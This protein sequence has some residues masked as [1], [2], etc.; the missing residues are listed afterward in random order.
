MVLLRLVNWAY[1]KLLA[2]RIFFDIL[3]FWGTPVSDAI[4]KATAKDCGCNG[5]LRYIKQCKVPGFPV[6]SSPLSFP[7]HISQITAAGNRWMTFRLSL[8]FPFWP[9]SSV[10]FKA[11]SVNFFTLRIRTATWRNLSFCDQIFC[12]CLP[13]TLTVFFHTLLTSHHFGFVVRY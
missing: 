8:I 9:K 4:K 10:G 3:L 5:I 12:A 1:Y 11:R 2:W 6:A 13:F 7:N